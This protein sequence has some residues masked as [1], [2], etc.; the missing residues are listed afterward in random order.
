MGQ[1]DA[2]SSEDGLLC[3]ILAPALLTGAQ[4]TESSNANM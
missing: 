4:G 1:N 3:I 2:S